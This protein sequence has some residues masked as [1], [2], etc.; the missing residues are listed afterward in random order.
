MHLGG[1]NTSALQAGKEAVERE[2]R[3]EG[4]LV[5]VGKEEAAEELL[6]C[7]KYTT[8]TCALPP[9]YDCRLSYR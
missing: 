2:E 3:M 1:G 7:M 6:L 5:A 9:T 4:G 8:H